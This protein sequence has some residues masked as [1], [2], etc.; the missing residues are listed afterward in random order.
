M[1]KANVVALIDI[2]YQR[3]AFNFKKNFKKLGFRTPSTFRISKIQKLV[4]A[5]EQ[6]RR[7][8]A[9]EQSRRTKNHS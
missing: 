9:P 8:K 2:I 5:P 4:K 7:V 1:K 6:S 3:M